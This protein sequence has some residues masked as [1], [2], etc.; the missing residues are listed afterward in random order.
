MGHP[1][2]A[3]DEGVLLLVLLLRDGQRPTPRCALPWSRRVGGVHRVAAEFV[4]KRGVPPLPRS[5]PCSREGEAGEQRFREHWHRAHACRSRP[6]R[7][8]CPRLSHRCT[9]AISTPGSL[10]SCS[11][12]GAVGS[13]S[14]ERTTEPCI[15]R[16]AIFALSSSYSSGVEQREALGVRLHDPVL[17]PVVDHLHVV[18]LCRSGRS[19]PI[20][21]P[22]SSVS[23]GASTS[24]TGLSRSTA[25]S[26]AADHHAVAD[27]GCPRRRR[28]CPRPRSG[29]RPACEGHP[30]ARLSSVQREVPAVDDRVALLE[31]ARRA[32]STVSWGRVARPGPSARPCAAG[33]SFSPSSSREP[34]PVAPWPSASLT[35]SSE[36]VEH[37]P[38]RGP[39]PAGCGGP[40]S[41]PSSPGRRTP[42]H[43]S[44]QFHPGQSRFPCSHS[45][46]RTPPRR[47]CARRSACRRGPARLQVLERVAGVRYLHA[48]GA[49]AG[50]AG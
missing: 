43:Q 1:L 46:M 6:R 45:S 18:A 4:A 11:N 10:P 9:G 3:R 26:V 27:A 21:G 24:R 48:V 32:S 34:A 29:C 25:S 2:E 15:E 33:L 30:G 5:R 50:R 39:S 41:R 40:C 42:A 7:S 19:V 44:S 16:W 23:G 14:H 31:D 38:P 36:E 8:S 47:P 35:V 49:V 12:G 22:C 28:S 37:D 13:H 20:P 17:D